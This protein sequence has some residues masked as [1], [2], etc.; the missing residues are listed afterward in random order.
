MQKLL[1]KHGRWVIGLI[2]LLIACAQ[3][4]ELIPSNTIE[5]LDI[6][7][8]DLRI[9]V[10]A[11]KLDSRIVI[12]DLD[13]KSLA[14]VGRWPWSRNITADLVTHLT[15]HYQ[16]KAVGFDVQFSEPDISSGYTTLEALAKTELKDV[17]SFEAKLAELKP[18]LDY[19]ERFANALKGKP[20]V[21][22]Y[23]ISTKQMKGMLPPPAFTVADLDGRY[24]RAITATG[25]EANIPTL[26]R[27]ARAG[28]FFNADL[29]P[30]GTLRSSPL[31]Q[32]IG[33]D[34]YESLGLATA[35]VALGATAMRPQFLKNTKLNYGVLDSL[36]LNSQPYAKRI[37]VEDKMVV[38]IDFRGKGGPAGGGFRYVSATDVLHDRVP[39]EDLAQ[40][41][42]LVGTTAP[43]LNDLRA[44]PMNNEYPGVEAHANIIASILDGQFK[45]K[46]DYSMGFNLVQVLLIGVVLIAALSLL[47]P[48]PSIGF[49]LSVAI[50]AIWF[51]FWIFHAY[52]LVLPLA[53]ALVLILALFMINVAWGYWFEFRKGRAMTNL[54]GEYVAP[55]LVEVMADDPEN[56]NMEGDKRELTIMFADVRNFT[57][58]SEGLEANDLREFINLYLTAMS[59]DIRGNRGTL[60]K[61]IGDC[62]MAFWGAPVALPDHAARGVATALL[63]QQSVTKLDAEFV[64][65]GW[66][67]IRIGIGLNTGEVRVGDMGS[68]IRKAYTVMGDPVNLASRLEGI[69]KEYGV[70]IVVGEL[71]KNAAPE[72]AYRELDRVKVKGK[73]EPVAIFQP[74][75]LER[76][77]DATT[78][79][80]LARWHRA[81]DLFRTQM[82]DIS[83]KIIRELHEAHPDQYLYQR[84]LH[85]IAEYRAHPPGPDWDGVTTYKTK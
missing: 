32:Q 63:M 44:A 83:E 50:G 54:F 10:Q 84:Y 19:D 80:E 14:E 77:L 74:I 26:Q 28:G 64:A 27:A 18:R 52:G 16:V 43:G 68:K 51:N 71:T 37:P 60:D 13:E 34:Y 49:A 1:S 22:G 23:F 73:N 65:R 6:F 45:Q 35:R 7:F 58:I 85:D 76:E 46:P 70:G 56:Y 21:L 8:Y 25:Y 9:R 57:S 61:Y 38:Q 62:V 42:V 3:A 12:V 48:L 4:G 41:I 78:R 29:D 39:F 15:D 30:D 17:P 72:F 5:R 81:L 67:S 24:L 20:V 82:W 53:T 79:S 2:V 66:P 47:K 55:E 31:I 11:P 75:G 40:R 69:T 36:I 59:E 33:D